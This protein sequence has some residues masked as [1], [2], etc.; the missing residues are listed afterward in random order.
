VVDPRWGAVD[1]IFPWAIYEAKKSS[2]P[3]KDAERQLYEGASIYLAMLDDLARDPKSPDR[4][5]EGGANGPQLFGFASS[6]G[7]LWIYTIFGWYGDY[8]RFL[9]QFYQTVIANCY[10][11]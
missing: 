2:A 9:F 11:R 7:M 4:Y 3:L 5:Q 8:V 6:G 10:Y 1:L